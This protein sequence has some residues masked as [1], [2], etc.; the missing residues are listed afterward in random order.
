MAHAGGSR[1]RCGTPVSAPDAP[2]RGA[3]GAPQEA[4]RQ[5]RVRRLDSALPR[6]PH[7]APL[8][9]ATAAR[10]LKAPHS[11]ALQPCGDAPLMWGYGPVAATADG[12]DDT[13]GNPV[14]RFLPSDTDF[15]VE[16]LA[17]CL[18]GCLSTGP[19]FIIVG[20]L[21]LVRAPRACGRCASAAALRQRGNA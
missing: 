10:C 19:V 16:E 7:R 6:Q 13:W 8:L 9:P 18:C 3:A 14:R 12:D 1:L 11:C 2:S 21:F 20:M 4:Q 15:W 17:C 5:A